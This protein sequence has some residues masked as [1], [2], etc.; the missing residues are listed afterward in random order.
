M[1]RKRGVPD[2]VHE[3]TAGYSPRNVAVFA[4]RAVT[5]T[6]LVIAARRRERATRPMGITS[7]LGL[8]L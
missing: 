5:A 4:G 6:P 1:A 3:A 2:G 8:A 7:F